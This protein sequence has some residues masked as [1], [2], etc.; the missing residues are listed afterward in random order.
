[1]GVSFVFGE[2]IVLAILGLVILF[3]AAKG[4]SMFLGLFKSIGAGQ[5]TLT[6]PHCGQQ[7]KPARG[8]CDACSREL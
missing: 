6:C 3:V 8:V 4:V 5:A 7:T 1:M 2:L